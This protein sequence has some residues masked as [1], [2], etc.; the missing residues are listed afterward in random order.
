MVIER[1]AVWMIFRRKSWGGSAAVLSSGKGCCKGEENLVFF[2]VFQAHKTSCEWKKESVLKQEGVL[3]DR[4]SKY[5]LRMVREE[6]VAPSAI[7][8]NIQGIF[9]IVAMRA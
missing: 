7:D 4:L 8:P 2:S 9:R 1:T 3:L 5:Q 6:Q